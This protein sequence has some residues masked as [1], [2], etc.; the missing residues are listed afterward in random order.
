M[1]TER[2]YYDMINN[3]AEEDY[4]YCLSLYDFL[5]YDRKTETERGLQIDR[6]V[7]FHNNEQKLIA[8]VFVNF[9]IKEDEKPSFEYMRVGIIHVEFYNLGGDIV[10][11]QLINY[12]TPN[13]PSNGI[14]SAEYESSPFIFSQP[15]SNISKI[16]VRVD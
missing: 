2:K 16:H 3:G 13:L 11:D 12:Q 7:F 8:D 4:A 9:F 6:V 1:N 10:H 14:T 15:L 5:E